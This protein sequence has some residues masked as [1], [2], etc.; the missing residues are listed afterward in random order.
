MKHK[1]KVQL[2]IDNSFATGSAFDFEIN[3]PDDTKTV[4]R[5][6]YS[7][8]LL[9]ASVPKV[10]DDLFVILDIPELR[11][12]S[13]CQSNNPFADDAFCCLFFDNSLLNP[14]DFKT[15]DKMYSQK[16]TLNPPRQLGHTLRVKIKRPDGTV[17][18]PAQTNGEERVV[19]LLSI[20]VLE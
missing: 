14:G 11:T 16:S 20:G 10:A 17:V 15:I 7:V 12:S 18:D 6:V 8:E 5:S 19:I 1:R 4:F 9:S 3:I 13:N 2:L